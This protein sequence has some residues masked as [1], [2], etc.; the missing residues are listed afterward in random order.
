M[1]VSGNFSSAR[2]KIEAAPFTLALRNPLGAVAAPAS[3]V[4]AL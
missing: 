2:G 3:A 4:Q 1:A